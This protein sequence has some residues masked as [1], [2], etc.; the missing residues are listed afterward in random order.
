MLNTT[1][2][3]P[4]FIVAVEDNDAD[5]DLIRLALH[6]SHLEHELH[7]IRDGDAAVEFF[8][9]MKD[10]AMPRPD[11]VLLELYLPKVNG[12]N[13]LLELRDCAG[14]DLIPVIVLSSDVS[15]SDRK[16]LTDLGVDSYSYVEKPDTLAEWLLFGET[17]RQVLQRRHSEAKPR[18]WIAATDA[19]SAHQA[20]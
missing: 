10:V 3:G 5:T 20:T 6:E 14:C 13:V 16:R 4:I 1:S 9:Q 17:I 2:N 11:L 12:I 15:T 18:P 7:V 8:A 19:S